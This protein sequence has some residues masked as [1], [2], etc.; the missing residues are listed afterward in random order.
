[1]GTRPYNAVVQIL[2][3]F[4]LV[5]ISLKTY[6]KKNIFLVILVL[7]LLQ[8]EFNPVI[9]SYFQKSTFFQIHQLIFRLRKYVFILNAVNTGL[10]SLQLLQS[11]AGFVQLKAVRKRSQETFHCYFNRRSLFS[12]KK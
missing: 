1:L 8:Y 7:L 5:D 6:L 11:F 3:N 12:S 9:F 2:E 10:I 4:L